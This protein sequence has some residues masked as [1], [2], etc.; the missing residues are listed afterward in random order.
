MAVAFSMTTR[1]GV[2][3]F[4]TFHL[5]FS[6]SEGT[7]VTL[8]MSR[9][10]SYGYDQRCEIFGT[11]GLVSVGN[12][13]ENTTVISNKAGVSYSRLLHSFP[14]RFQEAFALELDC[15]ADKLLLGKAWPVT[16]EHCINVQ[17]VADAA[18]K[19]AETGC[20]VTLE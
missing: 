1:I 14:Q 9:S 12:I 13:H 5:V 20:V 15:F 3:L 16:E 4:Q 17:K 6:F 7:V 19:S 18:R 8:F 10:A 11:D 2:M